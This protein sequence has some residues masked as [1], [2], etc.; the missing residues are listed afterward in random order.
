MR[1]DELGW[2]FIAEQLDISEEQAR[3]LLRGE[4]ELS[5]ARMHQLAAAIDRQ[6]HVTVDPL[7]GPSG[8]SR[9]AHPGR[10]DR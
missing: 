1:R 7:T 2:D 9:G 3:R 8:N 6:L 10:S 5:L 4:S